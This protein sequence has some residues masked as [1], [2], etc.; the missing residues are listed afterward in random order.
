MPSYWCQGEP[1]PKLLYDNSPRVSMQA[2]YRQ[3]QRLAVKFLYQV[4]FLYHLNTGTC[5]IHQL[6]AA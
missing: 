4:K 6:S 1:T 2:S 3:R 5:C